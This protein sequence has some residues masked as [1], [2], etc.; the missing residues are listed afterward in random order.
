MHEPQGGISPHRQSRQSPHRSFSSGIAAL[1]SRAGKRAV[2]CQL[3]DDSNCLA[4]WLLQWS[5]TARR[6][7]RLC[8]RLESPGESAEVEQQLIQRGLR[9]AGRRAYVRM[10]HGRIQQASYWYA[11]YADLLE[12]LAQILVHHQSANPDAAASMRFASP[13]AEVLL[14][15]DKPRCHAHLAQH[16]IPVAESIPGITGYDQLIACMQAR[17][18]KRAFVKL[19]T[20]SSA[21]GVIALHRTV[22]GCRALT[23]MEMV[24]CGRRAKF[25]NNLKL[26]LYAQERQ[27][28]RLINFLC[29]S[30]A[31]VERWLPKAALVDRNFDLRLLVI[32]G[33]PMHCVVRTSR[34]PITNLHLGNRRGDLALLRQRMSADAWSEVLDVARRAAATLP[35][36]HMLGLDILLQPGFRRP[37]LLEV[38]AFGDLLPGVLFRELDSYEAQIRTLRWRSG[39]QERQTPSH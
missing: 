26:R 23:S 36:S 9:L 8:I 1:R 17:G 11:G 39:R 13:P 38:N 3:L 27:V 4:D 25:Y 34:S 35:G 32:G 22:G 18:W 21:S 15:F 20:G 16:G 37:T 30:G 5:S 12:Q 14:A 33:Q 24:G 6:T 2:L 31:H 19:A 7:S 29:E 10:E 28:A